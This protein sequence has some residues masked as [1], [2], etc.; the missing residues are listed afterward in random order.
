MQKELTIGVLHF[1]NNNFTKRVL[2]LFSKY[3]LSLAQIRGAVYEAMLMIMNKP[4][5]LPIKE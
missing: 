5:Y 4:L 3:N 1:V 2:L